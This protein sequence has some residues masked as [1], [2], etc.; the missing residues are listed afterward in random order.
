MRD[1]QRQRARETETW[2]RDRMEK[3]K[4]SKKEFSS[5][6]VKERPLREVFW[7]QI[8]MW[9]EFLSCS[10]SLSVDVQFLCSFEDKTFEML[11]MEERNRDQIDKRKREE[12]KKRK[13]DLKKLEKWADLKFDC[14]ENEGRP[15]INYTTRF[16][17][18]E[19]TDHLKNRERKDR[20][21]QR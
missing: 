14:L 17:L 20:E 9:D 2:R 1:I 16:V 3:V 4:L 12:R 18:K 6:T 8:L 13:C 21:R 19:K 15:A 11:G 10:L 5:F 7:M